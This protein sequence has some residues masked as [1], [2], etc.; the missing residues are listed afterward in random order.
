MRRNMG[1]AD[2]AIR[3][4]LALVAVVLI[5]TETLSGVAAWIAGAVAVVFLATSAISLCPL[6]SLIGVRTCPL[7]KQ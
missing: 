4:F 6:Y 1:T 5:A 2:R 7:P 3:S